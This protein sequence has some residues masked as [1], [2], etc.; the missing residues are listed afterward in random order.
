MVLDHGGT[1]VKLEPRQL[2]CGLGMFN[3]L[4]GALPGRAGSG[5]VRMSAETGHYF[6][7][8][9]GEPRAQTFLDDADLPGNRLFGQGSALRVGKFLVTTKRAGSS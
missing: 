9:V 8:T 4:D 7:P 3:I 6:D 2:A 1:E 5:L